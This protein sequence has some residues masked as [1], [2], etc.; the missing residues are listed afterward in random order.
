[1]KESENVF[2]TH[3]WEFGFKC[4]WG[5]QV[6]WHFR[7]AFPSLTVAWLAW[8]GFQL[9]VNFDDNFSKIHNINAVCFILFLVFPL[10][11][12]SLCI[13]SVITYLYLLFMFRAV[14]SMFYSVGWRFPLPE[15][16]GTA[17]YGLYRYVPL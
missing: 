5:L 6:T 11:C 7:V 16:R 12:S 2:L 4:A 15:G 8:H 17:I 14:I 13:C 9:C 10:F 1:M 3:G